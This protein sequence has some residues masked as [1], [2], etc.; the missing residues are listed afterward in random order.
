MNNHRAVLKNCKHKL[1]A[2]EN[3]VATGIGY[4]VVD[5]KRT[6][7]RCIVC[8]VSTKLP[9]NKIKNKNVIP[10]TIDGVLTDVVETGKIRALA[11]PTDR[12]RPAPGGVSI[13]HKNITAG[14]LG[15]LVDLNGTKLILSNNHVLANSNQALLGDEILQPGPYDGGRVGIDTIGY[16]TDFIRISFEGDSPIGP[17]PIEPPID[18]PS[19]CWLASFV[20]NALNA[21][22]RAIGSR[23]RYNAVRPLAQENL[24][25]AALAQPV[26]PSYVEDTILNLGAVNGSAEVDLGSRIIKS[27]RTTG[28]TQGEIIGIDVT[29]QVEYDAGKIAVFTDQLMAGPISAG[30]DSGSAVLDEQGHFVGLLFAG[31]DET[32][33]INRAANVLSAFGITR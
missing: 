10:K 27:G 24:V 6:K 17:P 7:E 22:C 12:L 1:L 2:C 21:G 31:S 32:T 28:V 15:C 29:V 8:S 5:G 3:V 20:I 4:K 14:T 18:P 33:I 9:L 19:D 11:S 30:G 16:L 25:D 26:S 13:G 23:T